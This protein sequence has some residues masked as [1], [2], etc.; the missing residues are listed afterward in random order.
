M[1]HRRAAPSRR[2]SSATARSS[3]DADPPVATHASRPTTSISPVAASWRQV[4]RPAGSPPTSAS[5][6]GS[7]PPGRPARPAGRPPCPTRSA[8]SA[9]KSS[10][11]GRRAHGPRPPSAD[12]G[13]GWVGAT[14]VR[15]SPSGSRR[16]PMKPHVL[17]HPDRRQV[18]DPHAQAEPVEPVG[19][20][21]DEQRIDQLVAEALAR[22]PRACR[23]WRSRASRRR[24]TRS[25]ARRPGTS[26]TRPAPSRSPDALVD[27]HHPGVARPP[28]PVEVP[29]QLRVRLH[30][31]VGG[32]RPVRR[33]RVPQHLP[34]ERLVVSS[35]PA[36]HPRSLPRAPTP[37]PEARQVEAVREP[38]SRRDR[39]PRTAQ[40]RSD[41]YPGAGSPEF[42]LVGG[43]G[44]RVVQV[45]ID[46][47]L[48]PAR[49]CSSFVTRRPSR[50]V[51]IVIA[52]STFA[53]VTWPLLRQAWATTLHGGVDRHGRRAPVRGARRNSLVGTGSIAARNPVVVDRARQ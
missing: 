3:A 39:G 21:L 26:G 14:I 1:S 31:L 17:V 43:A 5:S 40:P 25:P 35:G 36:Q 45:G 46:H 53:S 16:T 10:S 41:V 11:A 30:R 2:A 23:R 42:G 51:D 12:R 19:V 32:G 33:R 49:A 47:S 52:L 34:Q 44:R 4:S 28:P 27:R 29:G 15:C 38:A 6:A 20:G 13:R 22:A 18:R 50:S 7:R 9:A 48:V 24:G 37:P 8:G